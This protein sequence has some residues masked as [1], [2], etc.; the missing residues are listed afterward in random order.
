ML[1][2]R[3]VEGAN[4]GETVGNTVGNFEGLLVVLRDGAE[5]GID[6]LGLNDG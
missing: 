3:V 5:E 4:V 1:L 6:E 2:G